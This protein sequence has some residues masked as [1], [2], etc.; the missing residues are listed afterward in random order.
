MGNFLYLFQRLELLIAYLWL[1]MN[2]N[3]DVK[4]FLKLDNFADLLFDGLHILLR[5][6]TWK[7]RIF[8]SRTQKNVGIQMN[9][10]AKPLT[11]WPCIHGE[12]F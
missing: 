12:L 7:N 4:L 1:S 11:S 5:D 10:K 9:N 6:S 8:R 2:Q 3:I